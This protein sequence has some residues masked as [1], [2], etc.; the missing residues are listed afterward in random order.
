[1]SLGEQTILIV[2]AIL[3]GVCIC[4]G[5]WLATRL[6]HWLPFERVMAAALPS[7][8]L[9]TLFQSFCSFSAL[10]FEPACA[11]SGNRLTPAFAITH[12]LGL[13]HGP[14]SGPVTGMIYGPLMALIYLPATLASTP[15]G[16][17]FLGGIVSVVIFFVPILWLHIGRHRRDP[18]SL[19]VATTGFVCFVLLSL[20]SLPL[21]SGFAIHADAP[22]VGLAG[23]SCAVL[24]VGRSRP[25]FALSLSATLIVMASWTKQPA[26]FLIAGTAF[27]VLL[28]DGSRPFSQRVM[29]GRYQCSNHL[30]SVLLVPTIRFAITHGL[31]HGSSGPVSG[32]RWTSHPHPQAP[33]FSA[34]SCPSSSACRGLPL[35]SHAA[36]SRCFTW[37][38][39]AGRYR[40]LIVKAC[41]QSNRC[42][43]CRHC[44]FVLLAD[45]SRNTSVACSSQDW[46]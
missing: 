3:L 4:S 31:Y 22:A 34:E 45:G 8:V 2:F 5:S 15:S 43:D 9:I 33:C 26:A 17:L 25:T 1:M 32:W 44:V 7:L 11:W 19:I 38:V 12:G 39:Q 35:R 46:V 40:T 13:Y 36:G 41:G 20:E 14:S 29:A 37:P 10:F 21:R 30:V 6:S 42:L 16:A 23:A 27:F 28:A 18:K 24:Y